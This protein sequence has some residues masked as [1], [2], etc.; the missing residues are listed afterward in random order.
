MAGGRFSKQADWFSGKFNNNFTDAVLGGQLTTAP[1]G[2]GAN[3]GQATNVGDR[4]IFSPID[5]TFWSNNNVGNLY[6]G[7]Y[8][9][10]AMNNNTTSDPERARAAFWDTNAAGN[11]NNISSA[12][13]DGLYQVT[14]DEAANIGV[15]LFAGVFINNVTTV[16]GNNYYWWIQES[17][18]ASVRFR[19][20]NGTVAY[21]NNTIATF[22]IGAGVYLAAAANN[23]NQLTVGL[24]DQW[25][26]ANAGTTFSTAN[27]GAP[28][29][30][31]DNLMTRYVGPAETLPTSGNIT[32]VDLT[33]SRA[34][35]RW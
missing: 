1:A 14:S 12:R 5:A 16:A 18:K 32:L 11:G 22:A 2:V 9:Y 3:A 20:N 7:T 26:N 29:T 25:A 33:L 34:S 23:N 28:Y 8:R 10:V 4:V 13:A 19:G 27:N 6:T 31:I 17:G 24:F 35:F 15:S 30:A 21:G